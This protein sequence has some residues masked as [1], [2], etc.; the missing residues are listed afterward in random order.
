MS[1]SVDTSGLHE[2]TETPEIQSLLCDLLKSFHEICEKHGLYYVVFAGTMLGA[3]RHHGIIPW[4]DDVDVCMPRS[5]YEKLCHIVNDQYSD[6]FTVRMYPQAGYAYPYGK[7]CL[8]NSLLLED[9]LRVQYSKLMLYIDVFIADTYPPESEEKRHFGKLRFYK[10][11]RCKSILKFSTSKTW[12]KKPYAL[13]RYINFLPYRIWG[14]K[15]I[16][17]KET[18]EMAKYN[19]CP[20][21][22]VAM[23]STN[24]FERGKFERD[25][26]LKRSLYQFGDF[27]VWGFADYDKY[28]T[29]IY[30]DYMTPP[31]KGKQ[32]SNHTY[33]L[34][35]KRTYVHE[36]AN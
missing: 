15:R 9:N 32:I 23:D 4:D 19:A 12:W 22:Y 28:L 35:I 18:A 33:R 6:K 7:F 26:F 3:V 14:C 21:S 29:K 17:K 16:L 20:C 31:P 10:K 13:I 27:Q 1:M 11:A 34:Y 24:A 30:G 2:V 8:N 25:A 36:E 5:D